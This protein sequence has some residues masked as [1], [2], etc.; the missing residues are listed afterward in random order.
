MNNYFTSFRVG[1]LT[2]LGVSNIRA[3]GVLNKK[4]VIQIPNHWVQTAAKT[5]TWLPWTV[6]IKQKKQCNFDRMV[7][8]ASSKF[9]G[10]KRFIWRGIWTKLKEIIF[11]NKNQINSTVI[12]RTWDLLTEWTR[13]WPSTRLLSEWKNVG[14]PCL[15]EW[16]MIFFRLCEC[17][18]VLAKMNTMNLCLSYLF[19]EILSM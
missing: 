6:H 5:G 4:W 9:S 17:C 12:T 2:H 1:L 8:I 19:E 7:Y 13:M 3:T 16:S 11:K 15:L 18:I 10:P 14:G